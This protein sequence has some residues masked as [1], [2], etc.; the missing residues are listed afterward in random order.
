MIKSIKAK[1]A[2][3]NRC[4]AAGL[5]KPAAK[6]LIWF[7]ALWLLGVAAVALLALPLHLLVAIATAG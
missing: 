3:V 1:E 5:D 6:R 4:K 7:V 2:F